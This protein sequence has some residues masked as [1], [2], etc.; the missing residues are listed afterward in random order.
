MLKYIDYGIEFINYSDLC[1][2][3]EIEHPTKDKIQYLFNVAESAEKE[4]QYSLLKDSISETD[5]KSELG[6]I[7]RQTEDALYKRKRAEQLARL[8]MAKLEISNLLLSPNFDNE[9]RDFCETDKGIS[10]IRSALVSQKTKHIGSSMLELNVCGAIPP[11]NEILG[12]KLVA[13]LAT[14]PQVVHDYKE[15]YKNKKSEIASRIKGSDVYRPADLVYIGT[16]SLYYVGSSQYNRLKIPKEIFN[17]KDDIRWEK[18]GTTEGFGTLHISKATTQALDEATSEGYSKINHVFGEGS[19]PKMRLLIMGIRQL[20]ESN[21]EDSKDLSKHSMA[22]IVYGMCLASNTKEYLLGKSE[23]PDYYMDVRKYKDGTNKI[24]DYWRDR[25]LASRLNYEPIYNRIRNFKKTNLRVSD[26]LNEHEK[27]EFNKLTE[28]KLMPNDDDGKQKLDFIRYFYRGQ[29]AYADYMDAGMLSN[30][31]IKTKLDDAILDELKKG[32]DIVLTGNAGD[33]KTHIIRKLHDKIRQLDKDVEVEIDASTLANED[34]YKN[35]KESRDNGK[36]YVIAINAAVLYSLNKFCG[37]KFTPVSEAFNQ[38][39]NAVVYDENTEQNSDITVFDLSKRNILTPDIVKACIENLTEDKYYKSCQGCPVYINCDV[40]KNRKLLNN[41]LFQKRLCVILNRITLKGYHATLRELQGMI[42]YL[43]FGDRN[44][45]KISKTSG[46]NEY[47]L[48]ELIYKG[49]GNLFKEIRGAFDPFDTSH[50]ILDEKILNNTILDGWIEDYNLI[51]ERIAFDNEDIFK[52]RK[53]Q[54]YFFNESGSKILEIVDDD[55][56]MFK[57]FLEYDDKK[58]IKETI[59]KL[60]KFFGVDYDIN[61]ELKIWTGHR[62]NTN[63]RK[64]LISTS[65]MKVNEFK[66]GR[67]KLINTMSA[68]VELN[69]NYIRLEKATNKTIFLKIDF[70]MFLLLKEID[71]GIPVLF[72]ESDDVKKVW[73]FIEQLQKDNAN[74]DY[75]DEAK[76][77]IFDVQEKLQIDVTVDMEDKKYISISTHKNREVGNM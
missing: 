32:K 61:N 12:G 48:T 30:V 72:T 49:K 15:R 37:E 19:S 36:I 45:E 74:A 22:R 53:R 24:I 62:Y 76:I 25:W 64:M 2:S 11:Y 20:L 52:L 13:L 77:S 9:W 57:E 35:W 69:R 70:N 38:M 4:R 10:S 29:S 68:G 34:I 1:T 28:M 67:P 14:S 17:S 8:L 46:N 47:D 73:R 60:N 39:I 43:I 31:H 51:K 40:H 54:F 33:G 65:S 66:I 18:I 41:K 42:S 55:I 50:P 71:K 21:N 58:V 3:K 16:T 26:E 23:K 7:S 56:E 75:D 5:E 44:C 59:K 6:S 63:P 27:W